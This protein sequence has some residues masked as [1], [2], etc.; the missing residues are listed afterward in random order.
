MTLVTFIFHVLTPFPSLLSL[1]AALAKPALPWER[2]EVTSIRPEGG[3]QSLE[4]VLPHLTPGESEAQRGQNFSS[5][6]TAVLGF[7]HLCR[8][9]FALRLV[10]TVL[11]AKSHLFY[12]RKEPR[13]RGVI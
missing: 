13:P 12:R 6:H 8:Q 3:V 11:Q 2:T 1:P 10:F 4:L 5:E 7:D 9:S